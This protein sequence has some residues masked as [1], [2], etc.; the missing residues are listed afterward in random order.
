MII[1]SLC[2]M[3]AFYFSSNTPQHKFKYYFMI[4]IITGII[5]WKSTSLF[6]NIEYSF[7]FKMETHLPILILVLNLQAFP[8]LYWS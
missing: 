4:L 1:S 7:D 3:S 6:L 2:L 8:R 5:L